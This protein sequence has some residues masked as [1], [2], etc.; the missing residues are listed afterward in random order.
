MGAVP[1]VCCRGF[2]NAFFFLGGGG[3]LYTLAFVSG[4]PKTHS[5]YQGPF[6]I[7]ACLSLLACIRA[8]SVLPKTQKNK[9]KDPETMPRLLCVFGVLLLLVLCVFFILV[10]WLEAAQ[11]CSFGA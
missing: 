4:A 6:M 8:A 11:D 9:T 3:A 5:N 10:K 1:K 7:F 2:T